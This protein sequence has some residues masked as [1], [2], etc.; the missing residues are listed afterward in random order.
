MSEPKPEYKIQGRPSTIFRAAKTKDNP[1]VMVDKRI[2]DNVGLSFK[3]KGILVYLLSRPDGWEV[4]LMD[5]A[6][7]STEGLSAV[8]SGCKELKEMGYLKHAG[9]RRADGKFDTVIWEVHEA[10]QVDNQLTDTPDMGV[11]PEVDFPTPEVDFP[12][13]EVD[14]PQVENPQADNRTQVL[15]TLSNNELNINARAPL[16]QENIDKANRT[17]DALLEQERTAQEK[18]AS[19]ASWSGREK[20]PEQIRDLLD[21]YVQITGQCPTKGVLMDWLQTGQEWLEV[22]I[23]MDDLK[24]AYAKANPDNGEGFMV[25]R[26]GSLTRVAGMMAG[27]RRSGKSLEQISMYDVQQKRKEDAWIK[28]QELEANHAKQA[29]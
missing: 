8:K 2:I 19:G 11:S 23:S 16:S 22:G 14:Y 10:P 7:R 9:I 15:S 12:T 28:I 21:V 6:N 1:Y 3:A 18:Q 25:A 20:I 5:L 4:N 29:V 13:P 24:N 26:P 17:V 27:K